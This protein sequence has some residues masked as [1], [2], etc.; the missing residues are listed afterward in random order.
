MKH[1]HGL[2]HCHAEITPHAFVDWLLEDLHNCHLNIYGQQNQ[3]ENVLLARLSLIGQTLEYQTFEQRIDLVVAGMILRNDCVPL[4]YCLQGK[5]FAIKGRCSMI[6]KV[7][8][9]DLY[10][11]TTYSGKIGDIARHKFAIP[12]KPLL[13]KLKAQSAS[14]KL[15]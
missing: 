7:C 5:A 6:G 11:Q 9:V 2:E 10:L 1:Y 12:I 8:G 15:L 14:T 3:D 13:E 4:T